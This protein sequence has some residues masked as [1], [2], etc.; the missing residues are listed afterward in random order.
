MDL[1][2]SHLG[3]SQ[4]KCISRTSRISMAR[5]PTE[6]CQLATALRSSINSPMFSM[7]T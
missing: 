5:G 1:P 3:E 2:S 7:M 4:R 6:I